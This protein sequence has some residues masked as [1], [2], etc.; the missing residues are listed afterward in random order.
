MGH[1]VELV[2][3]FGRRLFL[4]KHSVTIRVDT[5]ALSR[6][7]VDGER[8]ATRRRMAFLYV[9]NHDLVL[10]NAFMQRRD[11]VA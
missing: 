6:W 3:P 9:P 5:L 10:R 11:D 7:S 8:S 1:G 4:P 2:L